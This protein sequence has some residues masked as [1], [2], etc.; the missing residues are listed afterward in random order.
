MFFTR[1]KDTIR[2][3][4]DGEVGRERHH[5]KVLVE[6]HIECIE[7]EERRCLWSAIESSSS[8]RDCTIFII[9]VVIPIQQTLQLTLLCHMQFIFS[10]RISQEPDNFL[11]ALTLL[12]TV[13]HIDTL[14]YDDEVGSLLYIRTKSWAACFSVF[15]SFLATQHTSMRALCESNS[16][17]FIFRLSLFLLSSAGGLYVDVDDTPSWV[18]LLMALLVPSKKTSDDIKMCQSWRGKQDSSRRWKKMCELSVIVM[19]IESVRLS[20]NLQKKISPKN[21]KLRCRRSSFEIAIRSKKWDED[22]LMIYDWKNKIENLSYVVRHRKFSV[23]DNQV[24]FI[25]E[26]YHEWEKIKLQQ[27]SRVGG[28]GAR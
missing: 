2:T 1:L 14:C 23:A 3:T 5:Q 27:R 22:A 4:W 11:Y 26:L 24:T 15:L 17:T 10:T 8:W 7:C 16:S 21:F 28:W 25:D 6:H 18:A 20:N 19:V 13:H 12:S 9:I